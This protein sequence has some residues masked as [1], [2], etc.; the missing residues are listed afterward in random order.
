MT[1]ISIPEHIFISYAH[2]D[3]NFAKKL[4]ADLEK[5]GIHTWID[6]TGLTPGDGNWEKAI[7]DA[8]N[9]SFAV[10]LIAS[11]NSRQSNLVPD[12]LNVARVCGRSVYPIWIAGEEWMDS[13]PIGMGRTQYIDCRA[14]QYTT[15][16]AQLIETLKNV[17]PYRKLCND[18]K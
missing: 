3:E 5:A 16:V 12:E 9:R 1:D 14:T 13:V 18:I 15:G 2:A 6:R 11:R 17:M 10:V 7:R 4:A 8:I